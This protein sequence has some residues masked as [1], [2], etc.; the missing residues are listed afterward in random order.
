MGRGSRNPGCSC[1]ST[2]CGEFTDDFSGWT[3]TPGVGWFSPDWTNRNGFDASTGALGIPFIN[4]MAF[5]S[6][7][8]SSEFASQRLKCSILTWQN[9]D[10]PRLIAAL[11]DVDN[12]L[13]AEIE[14]G[15]NSSTLR[16]FDRNAASETQVGGDITLWNVVTNTWFDFY[17]CWHAVDKTITYSTSFDSRQ[18]NYGVLFYTGSTSHLG[19]SHAVGTGDSVAS[20]VFFDDYEAQEHGDNSL[21]LTDC[22]KCQDCTTFRT[23]FDEQ[24]DITN[25]LDVKTGSLTV[26]SAGRVTAATDTTA[27][28]KHYL[29]GPGQHLSF[30]V[31]LTQVAESFRVYLDYLD[32]NNHH[33]IEVTR[34]GSDLAEIV[35]Y[36]LKAGNEER[37]TDTRVYWPDSSPKYIRACLANP[38]DDGAVYMSLRVGDRTDS[39][40]LFNPLGGS[41][42]GIGAGTYSSVE[43]RDWVQIDRTLA[44]PSLGVCASCPGSCL[45]C[46]G[47]TG[48]EFLRLQ[49]TGVGA[50]YDGTYYVPL[51]DPGEHA[52]WHP[53]LPGG[54]SGSG[55]SCNY[56]LR[57][58]VTGASDPSYDDI[59]IVLF[60]N[61][62]TNQYSVY[63]LFIDL[64]IATF[65]GGNSQLP[66]STFSNLQLG[67]FNGDAGWPG[68]FPVGS[69]LSISAVHQP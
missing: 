30:W 19:E 15:T 25:W 56:T 64:G 58:A 33:C 67:V 37:L 41:Q 46:E 65:E 27:L 22:P 62:A 34:T 11:A 6:G 18:R 43:F 14:T 66:C 47:N 39:T 44:E 59:E 1:C 69:N 57:G 16:I 48:P 42:V 10:K 13:I 12:C 55:Q 5:Y 68:Q 60:R 51:G 28:V 8:S 31:R 32:A 2:L 54:S 49:V 53:D 21:G 35:Y 40:F 26:T 24:A 9:G 3:E 36:R 23:E 20:S 61:G 29:V 7:S 63:M 38:D 45:A 17:L 52:A 50:P 4:N